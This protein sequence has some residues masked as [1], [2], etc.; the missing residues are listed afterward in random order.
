MVRRTLGFLLV[1]GSVVACGSGGGPG[2][3]APQRNKTPPAPAPAVADERLSA[4][5]WRLEGL[6]AVGQEKP[7]HGGTLITLSFDPD[8]TLDGFSGCNNYRTTYRPGAAGEL[9]VR[10]MVRTSKSCPETIERQETTYLDVL[11]RVE[12]YEVHD[13]RLLLFYEGG[14]RNLVY[15]GVPDAGAEVPGIA[16]GATTSP[17]PEG[18][19]DS[20]GRPVR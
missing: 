15:R 2:G 12:S 16:P 1:A 19:E 9:A 20:S 8:G 14:S 4:Q 17:E 3:G 5:D 6:G 11:H 7:V 18:E 10:A 13:G